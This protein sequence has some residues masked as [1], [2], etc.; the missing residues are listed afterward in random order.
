MDSYQMTRLSFLFEK[1]VANNLELLEIRELDELYSKF[2]NDGREHINSNM[3]VFPAGIA[4]T[5]S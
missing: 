2:I 5:A 3:I 1:A 4:R